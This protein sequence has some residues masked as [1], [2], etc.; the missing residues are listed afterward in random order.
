[1]A[2]QFNNLYLSSG[3]T[4][5]LAFGTSATKIYGSIDADT[6]TIAAGVTAVLDGSFN[7][8]N[9]TIK[10]TGNASSYSIV[11]VNASTVK[12]TDA[13]GT[14]VTIPVGS[15]GTAIQFADATRTLSGSS[16][17]ILLGDQSVTAVATGLTAGAAPALVESYTLSVNSPSVTEGDT[18]SKTLSYKLTLDKAPTSTVTVSY[19]TLE[20]GTATANDDFVPAAGTVTFAAGQTVAFVSVT[21]L[22]DTTVEAPETIK[23]N[24]SGSKLVA[25]VEATGTIVDNETAPVDPT[26]YTVTSGQIATADAQQVPITVNV[27]DTGDKTV[28]IQS[29]ANAADKGVII[30]GNATVS[31]TAGA[32]GDIISV[33]GNA[34][35]TIDAGT[36]SGDDQVYIYGSGNNTI[37]VGAGADTVVGGS[38]NDTIVVAAGDLKADD[39]FDG[40]AGVDTVRISGDGNVAVFGTNLKNIENLVLD[41]TSVTIAEDN[42]EAAI[43]AGLLKI[44]GKSTSSV[45]TVTSAG[46]TTIDL[47][48]LNLTGVKELKIDAS[49]ANT[50]T[51]VLSAAQIGE[52][53]KITELAGD[54]LTVSTTVAGYQALGAKAPGVTVNLV[55]T[56]QNLINAGNSISGVSATLGNAT[57]AEAKSALASGLTVS[58]KLVDSAA[59]LAVAPK[60]VFGSAT[61]VEAST[62]ATAAQASALAGLIAAASF[63][64]TTT[65]LKFSVADTADMLATFDDGLSNATK[66]TSTTVANNAQANA[67]YTAANGGTVTTALDYAVKDAAGSLTS[68]AALNVATSVTV[69]GSASV[70]QIVTINANLNGAADGLTK[71][72]AGY[73]L[74]DDYSDNAGSDL[75]DSSAVTAAAGNVTVNTATTVTVSEALAVE[76]LNNTG[77]NSYKLSDAIGTLLGANSN[78]RGAASTVAYTGGGDLNANDVNSLASLYKSA[79]L[80][81]A[82]VTVSDTVANLLTMSSAAV[83]AADTITIASGSG[84][85]QQIVDLKALL[86]DKMPAYAVSDT[87][88][89]VEAGVKVAG[90]LTLVNLASSVTVTGDATVKQITDINKALNDKANGLTA[91]A[92]GYTVADSATALLKDVTSKAIVDKAATVKVTGTVTLSEID[93]IADAY[94]VTDADATLGTQLVY[95]VKDTASNVL[96]YT[97]LANGA[98]ATLANYQA[99]ATSIAIS[100]AAVSVANADLLLALTK[101]DDI[102]SIDDSV[103]ALKAAAADT[104]NGAVTVT[105]TD[106]ATVL[107]SADGI[108]VRGSASVDKVVVKDALG[109]LTNTAKFTTALKGDTDAIII[110]DTNLGAANAADVNSVASVASTTYTLIDTYGA[111]T[112]T[113]SAVK[114]LVAGAQTVTVDSD[115]NAGNGVSTLD[116]AKFNTLDGA[117]SGNIVANLSDTAAKLAAANAATA[118]AAVKATAGV[119]VTLDAA[120]YN[121]AVTVEQAATLV[122]RGVTLNDG[123]NYLDVAD[124]AANIEKLN[125]DTYT[126][127]SNAGSTITVSDNGVV[128]V[129]VAQAKKIFD[130][131]ATNGSAYGNYVLKDTAANLAAIV[132]GA[133][134]D[135]NVALFQLAK[136]VIATDAATVAQATALNANEG[137][138]AVTYSVKDTGALVGGANNAG[139]AALNKATSIEA[140]GNATVDQAEVI[141]GLTPAKTFN[142]SDTDVNISGVAGGNGF[143]S[144][145]V[146]TNVLKAATNITVSGTLDYANAKVVLDATNTGTTSIDAVTDT[147]AKVATLTLGAGE[148][149]ATITANTAAKASEAAAIV[150]LMDTDT[151]VSYSISDTASAIAAAPAAARNSAVNLTAT[152]NATASEAATIVGSTNSGTETYSISDTAAAL[153]ALTSTVLNGAAK[154]TA[155]TDATVAEAALLNA[156]TTANDTNTVFNIVDSF[157]N[158]MAD[159]N[160]ANAAVN[161]ALAIADAGKVTVTDASLTI[162]QAT[163]LRGVSGLP[164]YVYAVV[165]NDNAIKTAATTNT[166]TQG[167]LTGATSVV[168]SQGAALSFASVGASP[169]FGITGT[170]AQLDALSSELAT[171]NRIYKVSVADL[172]ANESFYST[173]GG[174]QFIS[175]KDTAA[176]LLSGNALLASAR[177]IEVD[178]D[179]TPAQA[180][181]IV[182]ISTLDTTVYNLSAAADVLAGATSSILNGAVKITATTAATFAEAKTIEAATN[183]GANSYSISDTATGYTGAAGGNLSDALNGAKDVAITGTTALSKAN[184]QAIIDATNS[185]STTIALVKD[186][187]TNLVAMTKGATETITSIVLDTNEHATDAQVTT[188]KGLAGSVTYALNDTAAK[189]AASSHLDGATTNGSSKAIVAN[190]DATVAEATILDAAT[191]SDANTVYEIADTAANILAAA[192]AL[193]AR[194]ATNVGGQGNVVKIT[195]ATITAAVAKQLIDLDAA[196]NTVS[197]NE[198]AAFQIAKGASAAGVF[199][200]EDSYAN[201]MPEGVAAAGV[202]VANATVKV[203]GAVTAAQAAALDTAS[204]A[205]ISL[206][207]KDAYSA[208]FSASGGTRALATSIEVTNASISASQA[209]TAYGWKAGATTAVSYNVASTASALATVLAGAN[210]A[211]ISGSSAKTVTVSGTATVDQA[212]YLSE[213]SKIA[214]TISD[215]ATAIQTALDTANGNNAADRETILGAGSVT[216]EGFA[217]VDQALG[218]AGTED[219]GLYTLGSKVTYSVKDSGDKIA[220]ALKGIDASGI[221]QAQTVQLANGSVADYTMTV[222]DAEAVTA[223]DKFKGADHDNNANTALIYNVSDTVAKINGGNYAVISGASVVTANGGDAAET[224]DMSAFGRALTIDGGLGGDI[225]FG[226]DYADVI[227][228]GVGSDN[229]TGGAGSDTFSFAASSNGS[230]VITDFTVGNG[231]DLLG[232]GAI[233]SGAYNGLTPVSATSTGA[234]ALSGLNDKAVLV[235][236]A[237]VSVAITEADLFG[238]GKAFAAEGTT[239]LDMVLVVGEASGTDG[240]KIY[241]VVDGVGA[242][243]L[244]I[245]LIATVNSISLSGMNSNNFTFG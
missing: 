158:I 45:I 198:S 70:D 205:T 192:P 64:V 94:T 138:G 219:R 117:T 233:V 227:I 23:L 230:D 46:G 97:V 182:A 30:D 79:Q 166:T 89:A 20:T 184:A 22:G 208:V 242:D 44:E 106:D 194:G 151:A 145:T 112:G 25:S 15:T 17:G 105:V 74:T 186:L 235:S 115:G 234:I 195:D 161:N 56:V 214:Y 73:A 41:G 140:T 102:Y 125:A 193:L 228:G 76:A 135:D 240:V 10:F 132:D 159:S 98:T 77:T 178:G 92:T 179:V 180:A 190:T 209:V 191:P 157:A 187:T 225:I 141:F 72:A 143:A 120:S 55:D 43:A 9:D 1:M 103:S 3:G 11:R 223:L 170:K 176:N 24:L 175:V 137:L 96:T 142:I 177:K 185:G 221:Y 241:H 111:L 127:L 29:D 218:K 165:D 173:L 85:V 215:T 154:L 210:A 31:V 58:Y 4:L 113:A 7:R 35:N 229:L 181:Q 13:A 12:V 203:T 48:G 78:V 122:A 84:T 167:V 201:L 93:Q 91:V 150:A 21:V 144:A 243:D 163:A 119:T 104:L 131:G 38:G 99:G 42:L 172:V 129:T 63:T 101:F 231:G 118:I 136:E 216:V 100:D 197:G 207:I 213:V 90:T 109:N 171:L 156:A 114:T 66:V 83:A 126:A 196:Y 107:I 14:S 95:S 33:T 188:L 146:R 87:V 62:V 168:G 199:D 153:A 226:T 68:T 51:L 116:V 50:A 232:L 6:V 220:A 130:I 169:Q 123:T 47:T 65:N 239:A 189:L 49:G 206:A 16:A 224:I 139:I 110:T 57:V 32:A 152:G 54:T 200:L 149:I 88:A 236:V 52:I 237:D 60:N 75:T 86:G 61:A 53:G 19:E 80:T 238:A 204:A 26:S 28:T 71:V 36:G 128:T 81:A 133:G 82:T 40:G 244:T 183:S 174:T 2:T 245:E 34:N 211:A 134:G 8:G 124:T 39:S 18:G 147:A 222:A 121:S 164:T 162:E 148:N 27:G 217:T 202:N 155:T 67:I 212:K 5:A 37:L 59:N 69:S 108:S 160:P